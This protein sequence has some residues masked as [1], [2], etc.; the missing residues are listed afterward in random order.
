MMRILVLP[1][2][3]IGPEITAATLDVLDRADARAQL[4][5]EFEHRRRSASR[6]LKTAGHDLAARACSSA[7]READG[8]I[9]GPVSHLRISA[10]RPRAAST[11]RREL[12]I[13]LDLYANIRP[14][15]RATG[16]RPAAQA[17]GPR[18]RAARTPRASTPTATCTPAAASSCPTDG[19][20][21]RR[22]QDHA[23]RARERIARA[24][25]ELRARA[26]ARKVTAVH[27]ANVCKL[28]DGLFLREVRK[29]AERVP[30]CRSS[31]S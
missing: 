29:V 8:V 18:D 13:K 30:R 21:A 31:T 9:L 1:G 24:A 15:A 14:A 10:A 25:F 2:D 12:R 20:G 16:C 27:K 26:A 3:G 5:L 7:A 4:G 6:A 23:R 11:L 17:D 22:A 28:S 19:H